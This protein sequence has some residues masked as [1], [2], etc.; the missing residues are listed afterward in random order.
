MASKRPA[1][2]L[3]RLLKRLVGDALRSSASGFLK[4]ELHSLLNLLLSFGFL[5]AT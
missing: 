5:S 1:P 2:V 3:N 4:S